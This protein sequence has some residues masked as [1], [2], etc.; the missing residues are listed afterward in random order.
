[1]GALPDFLPGYQGVENAQARKSFEERWRVQLPTSV[2]LT[3]L[4][5][6]EQTREGKIRGMLVMGE[7]P[8]LCFP[9]PSLVKNALA[10][11]DF[12]VVVD[13]FLTETAKLA[14]VVLPA[15]SFAEKE[16]TVTNFEGSV[17]K[18]HKAIE[19]VGSSWP[20]W[21]IIL[22]LASKMGNPMPYTSPQQVIDEVEEMVPSYQG[23]ANAAFKMEDQEWAGIGSNH[24]GTIRLSRCSL[25]GGFGRF[26]P[27]DYASSPKLL[28]EA[29]PLTLIAGAVPHHFGGGTR[30]SRA[31]RLKKFSPHGWVEIS[32]GDAH[33]LGLRD[34]DRV[35]VASPVGEVPTTIKVTDTLSPGV[36]FM[37]ISFPESP[38]TQLFGAALDSRTKAPSLKACK[39]RL[40]RASDNG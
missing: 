22:A 36:L 25:A 30:S 1:M 3:A 12:L 20:D 9:D 2:G 39:V 16:G 18:L 10:A 26:A 11:L 14:T 24:S 6:M 17:Q 7:N 8:V 4:E 38:V 28:G 15:A 23:L 27:V 37:P 5:M 21:K 32:T 33:S 34:G 31:S 29:Y 35:K 40:E 19:P 13:M